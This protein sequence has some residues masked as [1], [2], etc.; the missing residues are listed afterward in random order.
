MIHCYVEVGQSQR[1]LHQ[2]W[3]CT[4]ML[5]DSRIGLAYF[6]PAITCRV[7][8]GF[9]SSQRLLPMQCYES[10]KTP[11][12]IPEPDHFQDL[13]IFCVRLFFLRFKAHSFHK[14]YENSSINFKVILFIPN[15]RTN[16]QTED[17]A[18][19]ASSQRLISLREHNP[20]PAAV[21]GQIGW[22]TP[23]EALVDE[24]RQQNPLPD[25]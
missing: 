7:T 6:P 20:D 22:C 11:A 24:D 12:S 16:R 10:D 15:K 23:V 5:A 19:V 21:I 4:A 17:V 1:N 14:F 18:N 3:Q 2:G 13:I 8:A 9:L 25:R